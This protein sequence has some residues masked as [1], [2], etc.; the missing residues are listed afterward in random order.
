MRKHF[1]SL[2]FTIH[3]HE[4]GSVFQF[5]ISHHTR[6]QQEQRVA[7]DVRMQFSDYSKDYLRLS[8]FFQHL[9]AI[10]TT[11]GLHETQQQSDDVQQQ[12]QK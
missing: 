5:A 2:L 3:S 7:Y 6:T 10:E 12:N 9:H 8:L 4:C 11:D 1:H